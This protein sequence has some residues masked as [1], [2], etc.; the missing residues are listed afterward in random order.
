MSGDT[1]SQIV[2]RVLEL[3]AQSI[4][5]LI[6]RLNSAAADLAVE[7]LAECR[8][9]VI[10]IGM[11][12]MGCIARKAAA[13][14]CS[15]GTPAI[16]LP[17]SEALHGDLGIVTS[18]DVAFILSNSGETEEILK[19]LPYLQRQSVPMIALTGSTKNNL[20][21]AANVVIDVGV[22]RE[23][24]ENCPAPTS[25][26]TTTLAVCDALAVALLRKR[27]LTR[28]EFALLHPG[29]NLGRKL[30]LT[31]EQLMRRGNRIP[32]TVAETVLR[33]AIVLMSRGGLGAVFVIDSQ[34]HLTG[35]LTDGDLRRIFQSKSNPLDV[36]IQ[37]LMI[38]EPHAIGPDELAARAL[39]VMEDSAITV[40]PVVDD[41]WR[42]IGAIH[43][44]DLLH[45]QL[46]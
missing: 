24:D 46:A 12:K 19:L 33:E 35:I 11:G 40:L 14:F 7:L 28:E 21:R 3:E 23:A 31:V 36:P 18:S 10:A 9:R 38:R 45:A 27:G 13:T 2:R 34:N 42:V 5:D 8:G 43:L 44:H 16:F 22:T 30:L 20:A 26:T 32:L 15:T 17:A 1:T 6:P 41:Q 37:E 4:L 39:R 29:G 25:S